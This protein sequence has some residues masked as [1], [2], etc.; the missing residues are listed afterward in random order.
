MAVRAFEVVSSSHAT[1][2]H[3]PGNKINDFSFEILMETIRIAAVRRKSRLAF[4][5]ALSLASM[6]DPTFFP[7]R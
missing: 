2:L 3:P 4:A 6:R 1:F 7:A 5:P